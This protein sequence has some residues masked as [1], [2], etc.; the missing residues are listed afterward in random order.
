[1]E[2]KVESI[3]YITKKQSLISHSKTKALK[4]TM[5]PCGPS[6]TMSADMVSRSGAAVCTIALNRS[7]KSS[8]SVTWS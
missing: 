7:V 5:K 1:M 3:R 6:V 8:P 4:L 2:F